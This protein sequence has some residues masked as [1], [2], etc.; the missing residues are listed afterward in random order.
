V[1]LY[2]EKQGETES[3]SPSTAEQDK[4]KSRAVERS[5]H[6]HK[7]T[8]SGCPEVIREVAGWPSRLQTN[9]L[10]VVPATVECYRGMGHIICNTA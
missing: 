7:F 8:Y 6:V 9:A 3:I 4:S 10:L 1:C 2:N 5:Y